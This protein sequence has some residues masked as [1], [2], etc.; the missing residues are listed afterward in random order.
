MTRVRLK[1]ATFQSRDNNLRLSHCA[2]T[3]HRGGSFEPQKHLFKLLDKKIILTPKVCIAIVIYSV[4]TLNICVIK[5]CGFKRLTYWRSLILA[6]SQLN[7][8]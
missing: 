8:L 2:P 3:S 6:V 7:A 4:K 5:I 1:P